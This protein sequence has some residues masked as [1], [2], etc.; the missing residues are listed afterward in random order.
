MSTT[1]TT[2]ATDTALRLTFP[3]VVR[4]EWIKANVA[5]FQ[6]MFRPL[7][8][9]Y[10]ETL[11]RGAPSIPGMTQLLLGRPSLSHHHA[12]FRRRC[13]RTPRG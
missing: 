11:Q 12:R 2:S 5:S 1:T 10:V 8:E 3:R 9:V 6:Q 7:E 13:V 4:A